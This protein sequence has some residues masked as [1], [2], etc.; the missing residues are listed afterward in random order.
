MANK[1]IILV[2]GNKPKCV[3]FESIVGYIGKCRRCGQVRDYNDYRDNGRKN[4]FLVE[5]GRK[6][7]KAFVKVHS[8]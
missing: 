6:G 3:H 5:R 1:P 8:G 7:G 4:E 2:H